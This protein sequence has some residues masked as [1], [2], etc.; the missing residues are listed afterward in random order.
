VRLARAPGNVRLGR[1]E[2]H[3]MNFFG[4]GPMEMAV[5]L[6]IALIIFGPGKLP[7]IGAAIGRGIRDFRAATRELTSE[8][9]QTLREVEATATE[10]QGSAREVGQVTSQALVEAQ[11]ATRA[12]LTQPAADQAPS[13]VTT[14]AASDVSA[15]WV[16]YSRPTSEP[17]ERTGRDGSL[18]QTPTRLD[19]LADLAAAGVLLD[20]TIATPRSEPRN[21]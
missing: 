3:G 12:A 6:I 11:D 9:E 4:M 10:V 15:V 21:A 16:D 19:P 8:F 18:L 7:E 14:P 13:P 17:T 2:E 20:E 1:I 5:I